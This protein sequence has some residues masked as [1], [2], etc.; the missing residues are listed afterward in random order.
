[1]F[2]KFENTLG[3]ATYVAPDEVV[4]VLESADKIYTRLYLRNWESHIEVK[5]PVDA[6]L[7]SIKKAQSK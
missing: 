2:L 1:M 4:V 5:G 6:I 3:Y 7:K